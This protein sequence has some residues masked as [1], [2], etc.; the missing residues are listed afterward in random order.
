MPSNPLDTSTSELIAYVLHCT[1][2]GIHESLDISLH[3]SLPSLL[4]VSLS[5]SSRRKNAAA[6]GSMP[7]LTPSACPGST[8][9][10][11]LKAAPRRGALPARQVLVELFDKPPAP[12]ELAANLPRQQTQGEERRR[13]KRRWG[14]T[15]RTNPQIQSYNHK[16]IAKKGA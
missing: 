7:M 12:S 6:K 5:L 9:F 16:I 4:S 10:H 15:E 11:R 14:K 13:T 8:K 2:L 1:P 3:S